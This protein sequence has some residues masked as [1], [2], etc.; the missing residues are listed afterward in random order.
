[1]ADS[2]NPSRPSSSSRWARLRSAIRK[3]GTTG[4]SAMSMFS[5]HPVSTTVL[6]TEPPKHPDY[7][8]LD[9]AL[10][11]G[12]I[13]LHQRKTQST[14]SIQELAVQA[15]DNTGN[16]RTWPC[17]DLLG[18]IL[19]DILRP[20]RSVSIL[21]LGAGMCGVS[22]LAIA[23]QLPNVSRIVLSDGNASCVDNLRITVEANVAQNRIPSNVVAVDLL[24]WSRDKA[25][26]ATG[27]TFDVVFASDCLFFESFHVDLMQTLRQV[28]TATGSIY[29]LQPS[30]GGSLERFVALAQEFFIVDVQSDFD[31]DVT[32]KHE[33]F[34]SD[35]KY[36]P[37]IHQP[38]LVTMRR[39]N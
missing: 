38:I 10:P 8:W 21:E 13:L 16:I 9:Y 29:L 25:A 18:R 27:E 36:V 39:K 33:A 3:K 17:E 5:F 28:V 34:S 32:A 35:P 6:A 31:P 2:D 30:R 26:F 37:S 12:R 1:M 22:G 7:E 14:V 4:P 11:Q 24:Q 15:V 20:L 19:V 23:A